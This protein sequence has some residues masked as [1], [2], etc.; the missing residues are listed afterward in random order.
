MKQPKI[1]SLDEFFARGG[2]LTKCPVRKCSGWRL[3]N[4]SNRKL[5]KRK[6]GK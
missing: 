1:E 6:G 4:H 2:K 5:D 3:N